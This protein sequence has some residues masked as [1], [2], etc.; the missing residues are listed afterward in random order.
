MYAKLMEVEHAVIDF[1]KVK[2]LIDLAVSNI[3][4]CQSPEDC[5]KELLLIQEMFSNKLK[6]LKTA[7]YDCYEPRTA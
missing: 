1:D 7:L 2:V 5:E 6:T 3:V 4:C